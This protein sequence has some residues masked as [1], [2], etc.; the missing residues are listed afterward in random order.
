MG[1]KRTLAV[2]IALLTLL[3]WRNRFIQDDA[4]ISFRYAANLAGGHGLT[5]N[6]GERVEGYTNFLWT[7][8]MA[9][10]ERFGRDPV[11]FSYAVG[12]AL[13]AATLY[14]AWKLACLVLGSPAA[15]LMTVLLLGTNYTFS[16]YA[17]GGL[18]TQLQACLFTASVYRVLCIVQAGDGRLR[19]LTV[20]GLLCAAA[21]LTRLDSGLCVGVVG[22]VLLGH[23][24]RRQATWRRR[25]AGAAAFG[26]PVVLIV[27][28][29]LGWKLH[30]Y[31]G[32]LPNT[33]YTKGPGAA[34]WPQGLFYCFT[35]L[36]GYWLLPLPLL[37]PLTCGRLP[38][39]AAPGVRMAVAL[40]LIWW[41]YVASV[42]GDFM[43][44]RFLVP[45]LPFLF[46]LVGW[47]L[48][49]FPPRFVPVPNLLRAV[50]AAVLIGGSVR[51]AVTFKGAPAIESIG[52]LQGHI[53]NRDENWAGVGR[54]LGRLF[55]PESGVRMAVSPAGAIPYYSRLPA[56]D[57]L[58]QNDTWIA[59]HGHLMPHKPPGH[60]RR[61]TFD[62][63]L[64]RRVHLVIGHPQVGPRRPAGET[65][66]SLVELEC[67]DIVGL[68]LG[69]LPRGA[70]IVA[71]PLDAEFVVYVL[72]LN[73]HAA[74]EDA[75]RRKQLQTYEI[76]ERAALS[77][78]Q[79]GGL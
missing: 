23:L 59:R 9:V 33:Y 52:R 56:V 32:I 12:L 72:Y 29:W 20:L 4:F 45:G 48:H 26:V 77:A 78:R 38:K 8:M 22:V 63:L 54:A 5:W 79:S 75:I 15:G 70:R 19:A 64:S 43:E 44:F 67:F 60:Q 14:F 49:A 10:P 73:P 13:F 30:Y 21:L 46:L 35:F 74:V 17:T 50:L 71:V 1:S 53:T 41:A 40:L 76:R 51:H 16:A 27:G 25:V 37:I 61:A 3:A 18:E 42:G 28:G 68:R 31:G 11:S 24:L 34:A 69:A 7:L 2:A 62:Y 65:D 39:T 47:W 57:M 66:V 58:G 36:R 6:P 55:P